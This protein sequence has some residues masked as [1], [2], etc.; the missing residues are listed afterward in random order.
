MKRQTIL[1]VY[2]MIILLVLSGCATNQKEAEADTANTASQSE[3]GETLSPGLFLNVEGLPAINEFSGNDYDT[4]EE[5]FPRVIS[6]KILAKGSSKDIPAE[7]GRVFRLLNFIGKSLEDGNYG[8]QYGYVEPDEILQ[9]YE[10]TAPLLEITFT[11]HSGAEKYGF[12]NCEKLLIRDGS[13]LK[14]LNGYLFEDGLERGSLFWPYI[15]LLKEKSASHM[16]Y[17]EKTPWIDLLI[18]AGFE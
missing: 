17:P 5:V 16:S 2:A 15:T 3:Y 1:L 7:D 13:V 12:D 18:F 6:V 4:V 8:V 14:V 11:D 10:E 9:W